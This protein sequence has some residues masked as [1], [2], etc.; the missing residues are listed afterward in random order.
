[1]TVYLTLFFS[2]FL[3]ATLLPAL[4]ELSVAGL[5]AQG[6]SLFWI[7]FSATVGNTLG[8]CVNWLLGRY[9]RHLE[10]HPRFPFRPAQMAQAAEHFNRFGKWSLLFA[11]LPI[12]GDPLTLIAG[13]AGTRFRVFLLLVAIGKGL[14]YAAVIAITTAFI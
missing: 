9:F 3:A 12:V 11:W 7:W 2:G 4:S 1:M 6:Y 13:V 5:A 8:A 10:N 14:R